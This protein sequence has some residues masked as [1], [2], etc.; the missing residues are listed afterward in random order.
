[1][2]TGRVRPIIGGM[3]EG[4]IDPRVAKGLATAVLVALLVAIP[5]LLPAVDLPLPD[6]PDLPDLPAWLSTRLR[7]GRR[8]LV[9][10]VALVVVVGALARQLTHRR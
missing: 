5:L 6:L 1:M 3:S 9:I 8:A 2:S 4:R 7:W 10:G